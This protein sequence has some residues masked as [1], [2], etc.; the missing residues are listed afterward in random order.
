MGNWR[1]QITKLHT[2]TSTRSPL[3]FCSTWNQQIVFHALFQLCILTATLY[4][5]GAL[6]CLH[7]D[8]KHP[9]W[10]RW[11]PEVGRQLFERSAL[12][13]EQHANLTQPILTACAL[14]PKQTCLLSMFRTYNFFFLCQVKKI[15]VIHIGPFLHDGLGTPSLGCSKTMLNHLF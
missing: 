5:K 11:N 8:A 10:K 12:G 13:T 14:A 1:R 6:L 9:R 3:F 2:R 7:L 4:F 15:H